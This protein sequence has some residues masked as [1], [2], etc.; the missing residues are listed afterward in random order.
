MTR[1]SRTLDMRFKQ[2]RQY[3]QS[4]GMASLDDVIQSSNVT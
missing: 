3:T 4:H 2:W 1:D